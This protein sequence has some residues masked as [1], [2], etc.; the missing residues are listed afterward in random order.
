[1]FES[2]ESCCQ[3]YFWAEGK[4]CV[5]ED[6]CLGSVETVE[7]PTDVPT[8]QPSILPC[9]KRFFHPKPEDFSTCSN[10]LNYPSSWKEG[11]YLLSTAGECCGM[12]AGEGCTVINDCD[13]TTT[14]VA[15]DEPTTTTEAT[16]ETTTATAS[17]STLEVIDCT[18]NPYHPSSGF[19]QCTNR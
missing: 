6:T 11:Q 3:K 16:T 10:D 9:K 17:A 5:L 13:G 1:M 8:N 18:S 4:D 15:I 19:K 12:F 14:F 2:Y 7:E